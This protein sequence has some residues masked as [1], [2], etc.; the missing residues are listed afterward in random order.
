MIQSFS[1]QQPWKKSSRTTNLLFMDPTN[2]QWGWSWL[3]RY[4]AGQPWETEKNQSSVK[5]GINLLMAYNAR[6]RKLGQP[7]LDPLQVLGTDLAILDEI[8]F[9]LD[10]DALRDVSK[11]PGKSLL[12]TVREL[13]ENAL[14]SAESIAELS[15]VEVTIEEINKSKFN[16]MIGLIDRERI[17]EALYGDFETDK[18]REDNG[19][20]MPHD[21]I[22]N[23]FGR[24]PKSVSNAKHPKMHYIILIIVI[25]MVSVN[26]TSWNEGAPHV[27]LGH[28]WSK[29]GLV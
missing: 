23:M 1:K 13:V 7:E 27:V 26:Y 21:D 24:C 20:G 11:A 19:R 5:N 22:P 9:G 16:S 17:D 2:P 4:M 12:T 28:N 6:R 25:I 3:E 10:V 29:L 15:L 14:D 18:A 8:D